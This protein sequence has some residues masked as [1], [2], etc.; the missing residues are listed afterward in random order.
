MKR[1]FVLVAAMAIVLPFQAF[2]QSTPDFSGTWTLDAS[3]SETPGR[4]GRSGGAATI[5]IKPSA[6][7]LTETR[8]PQTLIYKLDGTETVN[9]VVGRGGTTSATSTAR[10]ATRRT[11]PLNSLK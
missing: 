11:R 1:F 10:F 7:E 8:G 9:E 2:A 6:D 5:M 4:G 3:R